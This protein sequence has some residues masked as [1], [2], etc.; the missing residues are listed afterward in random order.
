MQMRDVLGRIYTDEQFAD[1]FPKEGQAT[2][3]P[4]RLALV[5]V[6]QFV[7]HLSD[8]RAANAVHGRIDVK[9]LL[10][11]ELTDAGFDPSVLAEFRTRLVEQHAEQRLLETMLTLFQQKGWLKARGR[12]RT[13]STH[14]LAKIR[15]LNRVL[16]VCETMR[17]ALN[18]LAIVAPDWLRAHSQPEWVKRYGP[19]SEDSRIP[20]GENARVA[21]AEEIGE[22]GRAL[23]DATFDPSAPQWLRLVPAVNILRQVWVQNYQ[24][25]DDAVRW[26]SSEHMPPGSRYISSPDA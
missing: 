20:L 16:C 23:L 4:W 1:L 21:F 17:A 3:A 24:R 11:L 25:T 26:R 18:S 9:Y 7:E 6:I 22:Q 12:Q 14:V 10:G 8:Q 19:R 13:D 2:E 5:T 15:A